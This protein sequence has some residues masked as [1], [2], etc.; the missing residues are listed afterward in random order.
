MPW[1]AVPCTH[2]VERWVSSESLSGS[3]GKEEEPLSLQGI[4]PLLRRRPARRLV[5]TLT[6]KFQH[7][8]SDGM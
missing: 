1:E 6:E 8:K 2:V 4:E 5:S 7:L 3:Y